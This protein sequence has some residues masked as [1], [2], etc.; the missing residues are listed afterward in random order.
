MEKHWSI[1]EN[2]VVHDVSLTIST[3]TGKTTLT[4]DGTETTLP[5]KAMRNF[6]GT[7]YPVLIGGRECQLRIAGSKADIA[8][9][10]YFSDSGKPYTPL[11]KVPWW[12]WVFAVLC[13]MVPIVSRGGALPVLI[14]L[15]GAMGCTKVSV[16]PDLSV[17]FRVLCC[18]GITVLVWIAF[19]ALLNVISLF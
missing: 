11:G 14:G 19:I 17:P 4:V 2:D 10:G 1:P 3:W 13:F 8:V 6:T 15:L 5:R 16:S 12:G 7:D 9:D 18:L